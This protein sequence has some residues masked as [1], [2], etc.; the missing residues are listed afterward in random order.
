MEYHGDLVR[1]SIRNDWYEL[2]TKFDVC[3]TMFVELG[4]KYNREVIEYRP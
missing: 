1:H 4:T 3:G 2:G